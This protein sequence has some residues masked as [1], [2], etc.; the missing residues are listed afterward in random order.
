MFV[1]VAFVQTPKA[2]LNLYG[3]VV[4]HAPYCPIRSIWFVT[5]PS[6]DLQLIRLDVR[7][8]WT[9]HRHAALMDYRMVRP[10][11]SEEDNPD[12]DLDLALGN[13]FQKPRLHKCW[14]QQ[15]W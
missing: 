12:P 14:C 3:T 13:T 6:F 9:N 2:L 1:F 4:P 11:G 15:L 10:K 8:R 5:S 7:P